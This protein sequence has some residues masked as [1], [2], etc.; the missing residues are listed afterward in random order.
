M[1]ALFIFV[2]ML[3]SQWVGIVFW[4]GGIFIP[5]SEPPKKRVS[6]PVS[7]FGKVML[8]LGISRDLS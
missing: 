7:S 1:H 8:D 4:V 3:K 6:K 2:S 5:K